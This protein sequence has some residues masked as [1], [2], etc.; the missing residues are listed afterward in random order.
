MSGCNKLWYMEH[1]IPA[2]IRKKRELTLELSSSNHRLDVPEDQEEKISDNNHNE[3]AENETKKSSQPL[4]WYFVVSWILSDIITPAAFVVSIVFFG[5]LYRGGPLDVYNINTHALNSVFVSIDHLV[6]A[7][8]IKLLHIIA[9]LAF[10]AIYI[11]FNLV[12]WTFDR[13]EHVIYPGVIDWNE[14]GLSL[15]SIALMSFILFPLVMIFWFLLYRLKL[16]LSFKLYDR[17]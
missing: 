17:T 4:A 7:R 1:L 14:P 11:V 12:Y 5:A 3:D 2:L 6:C 8:P 13:V 9:P 15:R 16:W 10:N